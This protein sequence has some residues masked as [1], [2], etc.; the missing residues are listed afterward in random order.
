MKKFLEIISDKNLLKKILFIFFILLLFRVA[1][2]VPIPGPDPENV[3][4]FLAEAFK[5][6]SLLSFLDIFSGGGIS[7]FSV[8]MMG[9]GPY[10]TASIMIQLLTMISPKLEALSK[11]GE[12]GHRKMN[13]YSRLLTLPLAFVEGYAGIRFLQYSGSQAGT[14]FLG[15]ITLA[16]WGLMLLSI[17]AGTMFLMWLGELI[18]DKGLGN[19][20][21]IIIFA[22]IIA[23][24]PQSV[25]Q[26]VQKIII[27]EY[28]PTQI[29]TQAGILVAIV[30][31]IIAIIFVTEGQ[32]RLPI[33]YAKKVRG[34][35]LYGGIESF[36]P[37]K[38]NM[39]GVI[40]IIFAGAF[41]NL[42][43]M[44]GFFSQVK[45]QTIANAATWIQE[46]FNPQGLPYAVMF[47]VLV[48]AFTFFS[49]FLYFK[50]KDVA[51]NL[52]KHGGFIPGIRPGT[53]TEKYLSWL[54]NRV[55]L[56]GAIFLSAIA[57]LPFIIQ[58]YANVGNIIIGG[59]G[60]LIVVGVAIE[61]KNQ[62]DA[63]IVTKSY[64]GI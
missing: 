28:D 42:P 45:N 21:S 60:L 35:K 13:Q 57:V 64:E 18:T 17:A 2:H 58:I 23:G 61:I 22:G 3:R 10:I 30:I 59:T 6:N 11:E 48:F 14:D 31:A 26:A 32:R 47:F 16:D 15:N 24:L 40:P 25:G 41:M 7:R 43:T 33:S 44:I 36:L 29:M 37:I 53:Q 56:W 34:A 55:T 5:G 1:A 63:Q 49:T 38:L 52:Q 27:S 19:G 51:E 9:L 62:I 39:S 12:E 50:P 8:V 46:T 4:N 20:V 54:I